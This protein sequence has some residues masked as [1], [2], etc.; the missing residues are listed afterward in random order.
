MSCFW[1]CD[2]SGS[3][4]DE[5]LDEEELDEESLKAS[6][7]RSTLLTGLTSR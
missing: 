3:L 5:E 7:V 2:G 6:V 1:C 4:S